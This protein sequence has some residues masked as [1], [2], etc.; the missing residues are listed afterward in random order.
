M[1]S[2]TGT[3]G[4][5][6]DALASSY[7]IKGVW[8]AGNTDASAVVNAH[9]T[10]ATLSLTDSQGDCWAAL[11]HGDADGDGVKDQGETWTYTAAAATAN[12]KKYG[13][14][15]LDFHVYS[16]ENCTSEVT[17]AANL[18]AVDGTYTFYITSTQSRLRFSKTSASDSY[19]TAYG[20]DI[21][22]TVTISAGV[23]SDDLTE[24][25]YSFGGGVAENV[26]LAEGDTIA[27]SEVD[28]EAPTGTIKC[29]LT[30]ES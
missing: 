4:T 12:N 15:T 5:S 6:S 10:N 17:G 14:L 22:V 2:P 21:T 16:D 26:D 18:K 19:S 7:W 3:V 25:Y 8:G 28:S 24:L 23:I 11:I 20:T 1:S 13:R 30:A 29:A 27:A 9:T